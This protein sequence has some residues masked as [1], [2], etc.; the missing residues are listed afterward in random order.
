MDYTVTA[1]APSP[2]AHHAFQFAATCIGT[3][4]IFLTCT[5]HIEMS[6]GSIKLPEVTL[7]DQCHTL[8]AKT[9][10]TALRMCGSQRY[11]QLLFSITVNRF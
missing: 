11:V 8:S 6:V 5:I 3:S 9:I 7:H 1:S 2:Q 10:F 4:K